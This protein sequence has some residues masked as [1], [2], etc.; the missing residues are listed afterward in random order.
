V[1]DCRGPVYASATF[2]GV[3]TLLREDYEC[4]VGRFESYGDLS[5]YRATVR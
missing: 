2:N 4:G 1:E 5:V 3:S